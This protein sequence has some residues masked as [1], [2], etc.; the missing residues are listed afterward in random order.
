MTERSCLSPRCFIARDFPASGHFTAPGERDF[1]ITETVRAMK[2]RHVLI[3]A[4]SAASLD[5]IEH[6][7]QRHVVST[8][9]AVVSTSWVVVSTF[10][11]VVSTFCVVV[12][13][14]WV[15]V[16]TFWVVVS[17]FWVVVSTFWDVVSTFCVAVSTF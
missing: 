2:S 1:E 7:D 17:I 9:W 5:L 8:F 3:W 12:S 6:R 15:V 16:S 4:S 10:C 14:F 13:T 11:V